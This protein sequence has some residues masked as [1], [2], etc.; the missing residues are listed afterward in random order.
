M[1][2]RH[3]SLTCHS[4]AA[5]DEV[6]LEEAKVGS[7]RTQSWIGASFWAAPS[8]P[9]IVCRN[10]L[11]NFQPYRT[12]QA[13]RGR[14]LPTNTRHNANRD[15]FQSKGRLLFPRAASYFCSSA[16][17]SG[18]RIWN[19]REFGRGWGKLIQGARG[20]HMGDSED[21][22]AWVLA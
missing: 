14:L 7:T 12:T 21:T 20:E 9:N 11:S 13:L 10:F 19:G 17:L 18:W 16:L 2:G 8:R 15:A 22:S 6:T 3:F 4:I 5:P 1:S